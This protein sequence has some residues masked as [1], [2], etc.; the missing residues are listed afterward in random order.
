MGIVRSQIQ[1][2]LADRDP[3]LARLVLGKRGDE[4]CEAGMRDG[5]FNL[6]VSRVL[7][8][9]R[10]LFVGVFSLDEINGMRVEREI[11]GRGADRE[12][13][14]AQGELIDSESRKGFA[15]DR[16]GPGRI[17]AKPS[18]VETNADLL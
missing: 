12:R 18:A 7:E 2:R 3:L 5:N 4:R 13:L 14:R 17:G 8:G 6:A 9:E 1:L 15:A 11:D 16:G 10:Y